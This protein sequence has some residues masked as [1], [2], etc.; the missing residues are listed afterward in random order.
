MSMLF[1]FLS[2]LWSQPVVLTIMVVDVVGLAVIFGIFWAKRKKYTA[3]AT[4]AI[5]AIDTIS[6]AAATDL[7]SGKRVREET[8]SPQAGEA[9]DEY[10]KTLFA[11]PDGRI[12]STDDAENFFNER[13]LAPKLF[14]NSLLAAVPSMLTAVGVLAT[15]IGLTVGLSSIDIS[16]NADA[17]TLME[18]INS[19]ISSAGMS[20]FTSVCGV[21]SS[22]LATFLLKRAELTVQQ[23]ISA[24]EAAVDSRFT[25]YTAEHGLYRTDANTRESAEALAHLH[26]KIG[27]QLQTALDGISSD[28]QSAFIGAMDRVLAPALAQLTS[29][30]QQQSAELFESLIGRFSGAFEQMGTT[31]ATAMQSASVELV[32]TVSDLRDGFAESLSAMRAAAE[33]DRA[34]NAGALESMQS[35]NAEQLAAIRS[36]TA[37]QVAEM[38]R[39]AQEQRESDRTASVALLEQ[40]RTAHTGYLREFR[41]ETA[42]Q[43]HSLQTQMSELS[44]MA[45]THQESS[46]KALE[47]LMQLSDQNRRAME[48]SAEHLATS[49]T[50][51]ETVASEFATASGTAASQLGQAAASMVSLSERQAQSLAALDRHSA[52]IDRLSQ[53][54][55]TT[56]DSLSGAASEAKAAFDLMGEQQSEFLTGME[57]SLTG[58]QE[59]LV[60]SIERVSEQTSTWLTQ[61]SNTVRTQTNER[62][63]EWNSQTTDFASSLLKISR[64]LEN[65]IDDIEEKTSH[66]AAPQTVR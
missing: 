46:G 8:T 33:H 50:A 19:L 9:W 37:E 55:S 54:S 38:Q 27:S 48:L 31:Q 64:A 24:L 17:D 32:K 11:D 13:T 10:V 41:D 65:V 39:V 1:N 7:L 63:N 12:R 59:A 28:M 26:E 5:S 45:T 49:T 43:T 20:F 4:A 29:S 47:Q 35:A 18:G 60:Q 52:G 22:L 42:E 44:A 25:R 23:D 21:L 16:A 30:S 62:L 56:A 66:G 57:A 34:A 36:T 3:A 6:Q 51:L 15:F 53:L 40:M 61:Y 58:A 2:T 14:K